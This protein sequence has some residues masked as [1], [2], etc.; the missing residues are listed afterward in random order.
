MSQD[1]NVGGVQGTADSIVTAPTFMIKSGKRQ[2]TTK[3]ETEAKRVYETTIRKC[4]EDDEPFKVE[5]LYRESARDKWL[6][7]EKHE[8][9]G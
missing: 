9:K 8:F 3:S 7:L 6:T 5:L 1:R 4:E 2:V